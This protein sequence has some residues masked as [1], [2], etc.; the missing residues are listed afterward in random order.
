MRKGLAIGK[1]RF[2]ITIAPRGYVM[3]LQPPGQELGMER[4]PGQAISSTT[5][6]VH[7]QVLQPAASSTAPGRRFRPPRQRLVMIPVRS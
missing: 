2:K 5:E 1:C 6:G 4:K 3:S 7:I